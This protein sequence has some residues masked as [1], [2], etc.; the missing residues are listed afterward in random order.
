MVVGLGNLSQA[1][2]AQAI[3]P[4]V[5]LASSSEPM[6]APVPGPP[7]IKS[8]EARIQDLHQK[9]HITPAQQTQWDNLAQEMRG[10]AKAMVA[11]EQQRKEDTKTMN[12]VD[13]VK[14]YESVIEAHEAGMKK[15]IPAFEAL[16][17]S[18]SDAQKKTADS[19][20][21]ARAQVSAKKE[22]KENK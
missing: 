4:P 20:F 18:M 19:L 21:Q 3:A 10:N 15:F 16:Y 17:A 9:L 13:V 8:V 7:I 11:L 5:V 22:T 6:T 2:A 1:A 12:A 14:S